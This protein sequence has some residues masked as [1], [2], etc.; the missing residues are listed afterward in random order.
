MTGTMMNSAK[1]FPLLTNVL[2]LRFAMI[3]SSN[4][5]TSVPQINDLTMNYNGQYYYQKQ[6]EKYQVK[7][8]SLST[9]SFTPPNDGNTRTAY[10]YISDGSSTGLNTPSSNFTQIV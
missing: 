10:V 1:N 2:G 8:K 5:P 6:T 3:L 4:T 9:V 7:I